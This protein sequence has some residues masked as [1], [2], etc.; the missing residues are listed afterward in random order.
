M[1]PKLTEYLVQECKTNG[2]FT[3]KKPQE[4]LAMVK[5]RKL[6]QFSNILNSSGSTR[7]ILLGTEKGKRKRKAE[8]AAR[9]YW[10]GGG[11]GDSTKH[12]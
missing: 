11:G 7:M 6:R 2:D 9:K 10:G 5:K 3:E 12:N 4:L 8:E 1:L